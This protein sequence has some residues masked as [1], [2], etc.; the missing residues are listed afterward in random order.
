MDELEKKEM[1]NQ[2]GSI[3]RNCKHIEVNDKIK[4]F[5]CKKFDMVM[6]G[7]ILNCPKGFEQRA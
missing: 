1:I 2:M 7:V 3:C 6:M 5:W 4:R